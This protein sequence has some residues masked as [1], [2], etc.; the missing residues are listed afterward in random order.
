MNVLNKQPTKFLLFQYFQI[1]SSMPPLV[2]VGDITPAALQE[3]LRESLASPSLQVTEVSSPEGLGGI[4]DGYA[5][6]LK[7]IVVTFEDGGKSKTLHLVAKAAL[8]SFMSWISVLTG[9]YIF[10]KESFWFDS[11]FPELLKLVSSE[12]KAALLE[13][14]PRAHYAYC[15]Y[16]EQ[17][18]GGCILSRPLACCCCVFLTKPKEKGVILMENLKA[19]G[20]DSYLDLKEIERTSGGGVKTAHMRLILEGLA[21]FHGAW[22]V[23][24]R[25][26]AGMADLSRE[27]VMGLYKPLTMMQWKWIWKWT[28][29]KIM[30]MYVTLAEAKK[31]DNMKEKMTRFINAPESVDNFMKA[32]DFKDSKFKTICHNDLWTSQIMMSLHEDGKTQLKNNLSHITLTPC[33]QDLQ[34][35]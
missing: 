8:D 5:S 27:Q 12:Q 22:M 24:L 21:H 31:D 1:S 20:E 14:M 18:L 16:Q 30:G 13:M 2:K 17:D 28:L 35:R 33:F 23:W 19:G 10:Y 32:W 15:N 7:K 11:A 6:D 29:K 3:I 34:S 4:N 9:G 26:G 25:G